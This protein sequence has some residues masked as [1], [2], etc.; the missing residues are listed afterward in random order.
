MFK[1]YVRWLGILRWKTHNR[2]KYKDNGKKN[3][4]GVET[5]KFKDEVMHF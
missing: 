4:N 1:V 2:Q 5:P 3:L